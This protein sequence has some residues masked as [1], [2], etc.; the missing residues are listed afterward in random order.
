MYKMLLLVRL[1][2]RIMKSRVFT[3]TIHFLLLL[4]SYIQLTNGSKNHGVE[5]VQSSNVLCTLQ[6]THV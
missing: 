5:G 2:I 1:V 4:A 3:L 6:L